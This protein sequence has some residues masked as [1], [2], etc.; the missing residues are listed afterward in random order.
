MAV[1][2][3]LSILFWLNRSKVNSKGLA[4]IWVRITINGMRVECS[5]GKT[6]LPEHWGTNLGLLP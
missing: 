3:K 2:Q 4:P 1:N 5:T 6:I